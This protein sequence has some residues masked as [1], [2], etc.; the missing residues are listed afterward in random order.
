MAGIVMQSHASYKKI[1]LIVILLATPWRP[2]QAH[3]SFSAQYDAA[4]QLKLHGAVA[5]VDWVNPHAWIHLDVRDSNGEII[6]WMVETGSPG[7]LMRQG[8]TKEN[9]LPG[10]EIVVEGYPAKTGEHRIMEIKVNFAARKS[11]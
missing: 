9:L 5:R 2:T 4:K 7:V 6:R 10:T 3:H 1:L 8:F 11:V